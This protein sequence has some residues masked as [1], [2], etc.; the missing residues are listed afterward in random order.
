MTGHVAALVGNWSLVHAG[1]SPYVMRIRLG[2]WSHYSTTIPPGLRDYSPL[3]GALFTLNPFLGG[4]YQAHARCE[5]RTH[6]FVT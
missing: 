3:D 2:A 5:R 4:W 1:D 6:L